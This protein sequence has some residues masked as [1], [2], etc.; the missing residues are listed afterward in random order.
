M[1]KNNAD[2][3]DNEVGT[4]CC[5]GSRTAFRTALQSAG[6]DS[7]GCLSYI[8]ICGI[9]YYHFDAFPW[10][11]RLPKERGTQV[12]KITKRRNLKRKFY[13]ELCLTGW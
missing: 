12:F 6:L 3:I 11:V 13:T 1:A 9:S 5:P 10:C 8:D 2:V 7:E 4:S